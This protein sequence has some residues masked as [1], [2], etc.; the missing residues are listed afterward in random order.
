MCTLVLRFEADEA[1]LQETA[2][3]GASVSALFTQYYG[4]GHEARM[5]GM[6]K[7]VILVG[8]PEGKRPLGK[9]KRGWEDNIKIDLR[10]K[11]LGE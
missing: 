10:K 9:P 2:Q 11:N 5:R 8:N 6:R 1:M 4:R 7:C 3:R